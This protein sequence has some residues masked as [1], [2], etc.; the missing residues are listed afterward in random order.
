MA[1]TW[2]FHNPV[3]ITFG[4]GALG[5]LKTLLSGRS[6]A[7]V[8]YDTAPFP[9]FAARLD[10]LIG[11]P[12]LSV[13]GVAPNPDFEALGA[14]SERFGAVTPA[15]E[16]IVAL[17]GGSVID[18]AKVLAAGGGDFAR[19]RHYLETG[20]GAEQLGHIPIIAV[21]TTAGTGSEVTCWATVWDR[22]A[23]KK[24][25]LAQPDLYPEHAVVDPELMLGLPRALTISTGLDA[26]SHALESLWNVNA[27][28]ISTDFA[29]GAA[30]EMLATLPALVDDRSNLDL[31][32]RAARAAL[33]AGLAF[34]NTKT[35]L[36]HSLSYPITLNHD[37]PHG[38][39]CSFSLPMVMRAAIGAD[40]A[41][42]AA[43]RVIFG[44]DLEAGAAR[45]EGFLAKL[46]VSVDP[47]AHGIEPGAWRELIDLAFAGERGQNFIGQ[48]EKILALAGSPES[49]ATSGAPPDKNDK[50][51]NREETDHETESCES[52]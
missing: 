11:A 6:Y 12:V 36:A 3:Q 33:S 14:Y 9:S 27:N 7:L 10:R 40:V 45:L 19:V 17:G 2:R 21:P 24:Y 42:D 20:K 30:R 5:Q 1:H 25:S 23:G 31:R 44:A 38:I 22:G 43:L 15:P 47:A 34:S 32:S 39:A 41:C 28:P 46:G 18:S 48:K 16:V 52:P 49:R 35:A 4:P 13:D 29:I 26:L 51:S 37:V 8:T 50:I